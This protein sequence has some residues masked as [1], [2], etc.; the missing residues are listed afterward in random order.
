TK[1]ALIRTPSMTHDFDQNQR[2]VPLTFTAGS[3]Q[4]TVQAPSSSNT[5]PP[6]YYMLFIL[7]GSGVP[8]VASFVRFPAPWEDTQAPTAPSGLAATAGTGSVS[9]SWTAASDNVGVALYDMY[10]STTSGFTSSAATKIGTSATTSFT[11]TNV[12][13]GTYYYK[14]QA[15]DA[16]G[17][18]GS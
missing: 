13:P 1:V 15:E 17:N 11:N 6:G 9:L 7:N 3:G 16:V 10:R 14:V 2:F 8:S 12:A 18:A 4:L 5:A